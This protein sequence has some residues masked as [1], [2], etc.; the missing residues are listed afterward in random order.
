MQEQTMIA[1]TRLKRSTVSTVKFLHAAK[2][3][4]IRLNP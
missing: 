1:K 3:K 4:E 2:R